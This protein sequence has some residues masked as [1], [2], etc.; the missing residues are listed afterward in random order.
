[1]REFAASC[2]APVPTLALLLQPV[3]VVA[4]VLV[5]PAAALA[6]FGS[7]AGLAAAVPLAAVLAVGSGSDGR[8]G[9][10]VLG[11]LVSA[12][13]LAALVAGAIVL[14]RPGSRAVDSVASC[15]AAMIRPTSPPRP[16]STSWPCG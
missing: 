8:A 13:Y 14:W 15:S 7:I 16:R 9:A 12:V 4:L 1:M 2:P 6:A 11:I 3:I 5:P 10:P